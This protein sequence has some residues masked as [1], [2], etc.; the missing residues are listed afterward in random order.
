VS[1]PIEGMPG[2]VAYLKPSHA[3]PDRPPVMVKRLAFPRGKVP[4]QLQPYVEA[5]KALK[6]ERKE[7]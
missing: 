5:I 4:P 2:A 1:Y 6:K 3:R 7:V